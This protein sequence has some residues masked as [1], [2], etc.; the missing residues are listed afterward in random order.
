MIHLDTPRGDLIAIIELLT[1]LVTSG[2]E[3]GA[4]MKEAAERAAALSGAT[5]SVV[6]LVDGEEMVCRAAW[7]TAANSL[8]LRLRR[9]A[10]LSG[11][12][13]ERG[14]PLRCDDA[15]GDPRV[16]RA[17]SVRM[18]AG[19][20]IC[21][22][23]FHSSE[24]VGVLKVLSREK[25]AF[26][27]SDVEMM[28]LLAT[29]IGSSLANADRYARAEFESTHDPLTQLRNRRS[30][31]ADLAAETARAKRYG[32][33][34]TLALLDLNGFKAVNDSLGHPAGDEVLRATGAALLRS[35]R[36][37]D[38]CFRIGGDE[39]AILI[40]E[41]GRQPAVEMLARMMVEIAAVKPG[42]SA[43]AGLVELEPWMKAEDLHAA[44]DEALYADKNEYQRFARERRLA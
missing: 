44:A 29:V 9:V 22:P 19:S 2:L 14:V 12:C 10:S 39:F 3:P 18:E 13:V 8:G 1:A 38:R 43:S 20:M 21:V 36:V 4:V 7:G 25:H 28:R 26:D 11:L 30:Y 16:D 32:R 35:T 33:P 34:L 23:L 41:T 27:D 15:E 40:P 17:A 42:I 5:G 24:T 37:V 6:E 31:D